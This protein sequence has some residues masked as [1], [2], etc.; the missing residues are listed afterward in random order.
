MYI[1]EILLHEKSLPKIDLVGIISHALSITKERVFAEPERILR[2]PEL[3]RIREMI[4][5]R[6]R[7]KPFAYLTHC[8]EFFSEPFYVD[9]RVL[10]PRPETELLVEEALRAI[11]ESHRPLRVLDMGCGSGIIGI[12]L[13]KGGAEKVFSADISPA[14]LAVAKW[15]ARALAVEDKIT[16]IASDL[17]S[18]VKSGTTFDLICANLPYVSV[19]EWENLEDDVRLFEPKQALV[20]GKEGIELYVRYLKELTAYLGRAGTVLCEIGG[21]SQADVIGS[22]LSSTG[23]K[24]AVKKDLAGRKRVVKGSWTNLS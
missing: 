5:A 21:D 22:V 24:V 3:S 11:R 1:S 16:F 20:G 23:L 14:A 13:A 10:I 8:K 9:E 17:F 2:P 4:E 7:G 15:N 6:R 18:A 12:M 19:R